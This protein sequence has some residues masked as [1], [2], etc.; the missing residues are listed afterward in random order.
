MAGMLVKRRNFSEA[1]GCCG[2]RVSQNAIV[3]ETNQ[4]CGVYLL[5][6]CLFTGYR[7]I[8]IIS[9]YLYRSLYWLRPIVVQNHPNLVKT[10]QVYKFLLG[11]R[12]NADG[13]AGHDVTLPLQRLPVKEVFEGQVLRQSVFSFMWIV[14]GASI[15]LVASLLARRESASTARSPQARRPRVGAIYPVPGSGRGREGAK[16][17]VEDPPPPYQGLDTSL[18]PYACVV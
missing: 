7:F 4:L 6:L 13:R 18:P 2:V 17:Q 1:L 14:S 10:T 12:D 3:S 15:L 8:I 11:R 16:C 9:E 5:I